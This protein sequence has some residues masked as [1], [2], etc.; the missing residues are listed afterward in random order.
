M[1]SKPQSKFGDI[2][3][4]Y[5][6]IQQSINKGIQKTFKENVIDNSTIPNKCINYVENKVESPN[7]KIHIQPVAR[8]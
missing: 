5:R 7:I 8:E 1:T 6:E 4:V 3:E 2:N